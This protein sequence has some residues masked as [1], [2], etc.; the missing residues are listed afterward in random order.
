MLHSFLYFCL[1]FPVVS[2]S[3]NPTEVG[4]YLKP[5]DD[6]LDFMLVEEMFQ[7]ALVSEANDKLKHQIVAP[8]LNCEYDGKEF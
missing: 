3:G 4:S 5:A 2:S 7:A 1:S 8:V 6:M